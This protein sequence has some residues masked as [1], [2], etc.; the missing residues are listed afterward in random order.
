MTFGETP[1]SAA[2]AN[3]HDHVVRFLIAKDARLLMTGTTPL[4]GAAR[5]GHPTVARMLL[6]SFRADRYANEDL[7]NVMHPPYLLGALDHLGEMALHQAARNSHEEVVKVMLERDIPTIEW[8]R[9]TTPVSSGKQTALDLAAA[10]GH[11][12]V[13]MLLRDDRD[14]NSSNGQGQTPLILAARGNQIPLLK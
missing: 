6:Q 2:A 3:G 11:L 13:V 7:P 9:A 4:H 12:A 1:I 10:N 14:F 8:L 5:N